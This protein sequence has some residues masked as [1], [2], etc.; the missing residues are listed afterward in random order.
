MIDDVEKTDVMAETPPAVG[1]TAVV[2]SCWSST[3]AK[4]HALK[5]LSLL[6]QWWNRISYSHC[7][8]HLVILYSEAR[9]RRRC[10]AQAKRRSNKAVQHA[11]DHLFVGHWTGR[12]ILHPHSISKGVPLQYVIFKEPWPW[13]GWE[14]IS[15]VVVSPQSGTVV[16]WGLSECFT[17]IARYSNNTENNNTAA[18]DNLPSGFGQLLAGEPENSPG[19]TSFLQVSCSFPGFIVSPS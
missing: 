5:T 10:Q 18:N 15:W 6:S 14:D 2:A 1:K 3:Q 8:W 7:Q 13:M 17:T 9:E 11:L 12:S 16:I 19:P 4:K